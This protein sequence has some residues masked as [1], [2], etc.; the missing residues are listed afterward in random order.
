MRCPWGTVFHRVLQNG[1]FPQ[2]AAFG[3]GLLLCRMWF[4]PKKKNQL[5]HGPQFLPGTPASAWAL[6]RLQHRYLHWDHPVC[7]SRTA[8]FTTLLITT[9]KSLLHLLKYLFPPSPDLCACRAV[10]LIHSPSQLLYN[11][12]C[13]FLNI[14]STN[15]IHWLGF[16]QLSSNLP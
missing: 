16:G 14:L 12:L 4:L 1:A 6:H 2:G 9:A 13:P 11:S 7:C 3:K 15:I 10:S 5:Q 8:C